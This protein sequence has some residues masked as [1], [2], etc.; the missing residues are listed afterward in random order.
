MLQVDTGEHR[1]PVEFSHAAFRIAWLVRFYYAFVAFG[2]TSFLHF[3]NAFRGL[4]LRDPLWPL[5]LLDTLTG[6]DWLAQVEL[7]TAAGVGIAVF[8]ALWP[9]VLLFRLG[10]FL[11]VFLFST[12]DGSYGYVNHSWHLFIYVSFGLLFLPSAIGRPENLS[13]REAMRTNAAFWL[14]QSL[15][16]LSYSLA[17]FW[18]FWHSNLELFASDGFVRIVLSRLMD[19]F[20]GTVPALVPW[21]AEYEFLAQFFFLSF[22][23]VEATMIM[24]L[25]RPHLQVFYGVVV[26]LFHF[27]LPWVFG[28]GGGL[29]PLLWFLFLV[30]SP[31]AASRFSPGATARSLPILGIPF[32]AFARWRRTGKRTEKAW[33][34]YDG[35]CPFCS[36][37]ARLLDVREAV[38]ELVLV[39]ARDGGP[40][41]DEIRALPWDLNRGMVLKRDGRYRFGDEALRTLALLSRRRGVFSIL[42]RLVLGSRAVAWCAYPLM[43]LC[44]RLALTA[45]RVPSLG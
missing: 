32:R 18:K 30:F 34:V 8:A 33:L 39:N 36:R 40:I 45:K 20:S 43:R 31:F 26:I 41:V 5:D 25:F 37:Y 15:P 1:R 44:R 22:C 7:L 28:F 6:L 17:G 10:V 19:E 4:P 14:T 38:G 35:E 16:L 13:R 24:A 42:N 9:G 23:F 21:I 12:L 2:M 29:Y 3:P 11:Y 27:S